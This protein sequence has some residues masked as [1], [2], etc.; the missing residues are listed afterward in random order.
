MK[1]L[2]TLSLAA[3]VGLNACKKI[4]S[5]QP[6][7]TQS[8][9]NSTADVSCNHEMYSYIPLIKD[10]SKQNS[11][12]NTSFPQTYYRLSNSAVTKKIY[13]SFAYPLCINLY[14]ADFIRFYL[15]KPDGQE[16][17]MGSVDPHLVDGL[18]IELP[19]EVFN[20]GAYSSAYDSQ[21][22]RYSL[23]LEYGMG[24]YSPSNIYEKSSDAYITSTYN[25]GA[26]GAE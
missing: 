25:G 17:Y 15:T 7:P 13:A 20:G 24:T 1:L 6:T 19:L 22:G 21:V 16:L 10:E 11:L 9:L 5:D 26:G 2:L 8:Q 18:L 4:D 14:H 3:I 12:N 23:K